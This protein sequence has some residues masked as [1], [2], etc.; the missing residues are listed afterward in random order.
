MSLR[1]ALSAALLIA[2]APALAQ[3]PAASS[4]PPAPSSPPPSAAPAGPGAAIQPAAMAYSQ[5]LSTGV[6][7]VAATATPEAG[8][9]SVMNGCA[10]QRTA[11][12][13]AVEALLATLPADQQAA[14]RAQ[15]Q[16]QIGAVPTQLADAIRQSRAPATPA[17]PAPAATPH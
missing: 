4:T 13:Q 17:T 15:Y 1:F 11:L 3:P 2:A 14:G 9:T 5:C 10:T 12:D 16:S 6:S 7:G 8:A